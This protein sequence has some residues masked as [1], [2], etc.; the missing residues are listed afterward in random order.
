V[1]MRLDEFV[2]PANTSG[3]GLRGH[4]PPPPGTELLST[5]SWELHDR[6]SG[7]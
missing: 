1:S 6:G 3:R 2:H 5:K 7:W 4:R